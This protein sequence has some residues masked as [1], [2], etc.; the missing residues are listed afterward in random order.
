MIRFS[1]SSPPVR[2]GIPAG[3]KRE[4]LSSIKTRFHSWGQSLASHDEDY[5]D[6]EELDPAEVIGPPRQ[7]IEDAERLLTQLE[8]SGPDLSPRDCIILFVSVADLRL[9]DWGRVEM[10]WTPERRR[11]VE[12]ASRQLYGRLQAQT[13]LNRTA[14]LDLLE[15]GIQELI[16]DSRIS[17]E[18]HEEIRRTH[19]EPW[20]YNTSYEFDSEVIFPVDEIGYILELLRDLRVE[21]REGTAALVKQ[22]DST[23]RMSLPEIAEEYRRGGDSIDSSRPDMY[24][25]SFWWKRL[26]G[27]KPIA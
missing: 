5:V 14:L 18:Q 13:G 16:E 7:L 27:A 12:V 17:L 1:A 25:E 15:S 9:T 11:K 8:H 6:P 2:Y 20:H 23:L 26:P 3:A 4:I 24:P 22:L 19:S 21:L 10:L